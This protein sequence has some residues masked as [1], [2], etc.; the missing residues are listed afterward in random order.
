MKLAGCDLLTIAPDLLEKLS[1][2]GGAVERVL[3][4]ESAKK[5]SIEKTPLD[6][7]SYRWSHNEDAMAVEKLSEGIRK[8]DADARKL[9]QYVAALM[10]SSRA[11]A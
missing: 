10:K 3:S 11:A 6:E 4:P 2:V 8:F 7:A 1:K 5:L 9:E